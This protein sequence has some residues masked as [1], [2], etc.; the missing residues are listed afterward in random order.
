MA[1]LS[2]QFKF[3]SVFIF[4]QCPK[5][6]DLIYEATSFIIRSNL[7][8]FCRHKKVLQHC[9]FFLAFSC[10]ASTYKKDIFSI[11]TDIKHGK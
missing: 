11:V 9:D 10:S 6:I 1:N 2:H 3:N 4:S 5:N 7:D 8:R